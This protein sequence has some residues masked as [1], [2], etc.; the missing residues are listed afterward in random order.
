MRARLR[1][2]VRLRRPAL[3]GQAAYWG[4]AAYIT[5][6]LVSH[7]GL[8]G[9]SGFLIGV[10]ASTAMAIVF[11]LVIAQKKGIYFSMITFAFAEIV[12]FVVNQLPHYT[13]GEDGLHDILRGRLFGISL[14]NDRVF[15]YVALVFVG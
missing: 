15:Y 11:G 5:G 8:P 14:A 3:F 2:A 6:V 4:A 1:P 12:Y 7:F 9:W 10:A 13:G